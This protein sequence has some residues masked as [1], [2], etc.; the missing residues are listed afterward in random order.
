MRLQRSLVLVSGGLGLVALVLIGRSIV[1]GV[2]PAATATPT[3]EAP[4]IVA[5]S[6]S[7]TSEPFHLA[8]GTY[9]TDWSAWGAAAEYP[10]CMHS[11]ELVALAADGSMAS[12]SP[13]AKAELTHLVDVPATGASGEIYVYNV[14]AGDYELNV[15]SAC[16]WQIALSS[17]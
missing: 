4:I 6:G 12:P 13:S 17:D 11:A 9:R 2:P 1:A 5:G 8:G 3:A 15:R 14:A 16:S 7:Q 10:P